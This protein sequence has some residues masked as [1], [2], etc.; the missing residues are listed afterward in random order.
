MW[1]DYEENFGLLSHAMDCYDRATRDVPSMETW[2]LYLA[3]AANYYGIA[4][5]R[6]VYE[7]AMRHLKN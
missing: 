3:K 5:T 1:A 2:N 4:R 6:Q 7:K